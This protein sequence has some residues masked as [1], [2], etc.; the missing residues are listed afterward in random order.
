MKKGYW[1]IRTYESGIIGEKIKYWVKGER[2]SGKSRRKE[3][4]E[5]KKQEQ[6]EYSATKALARLLN[7]NY[8]EG[9]ILLGFDY[10]DEG[11]KK[12]IRYLDLKHPDHGITLEG[13]I[14]KELT[15]E[16]RDM[17]IEAAWHEIELCIRRT[18]RELKKQSQELFSVA[19]T[20]DMDGETKEHVRVHHH[21]VVK[22]G[23]EKIFQEK[24]KALGKVD[25]K[26]LSKQADYLPIAEY[27]IK[28]VRHIP[29]AKKFRSSR[30]LV[31]PQPSD[32]V[33][34][35]DAEI[36]I[37]KGGKLL[38]RQEYRNSSGS[39]HYQPQYI[40]YIIPEDKRRKRESDRK[41]NEEVQRL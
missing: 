38:F 36:R 39:A 4:S 9:D 6:N 18:S 32:R 24:W 10:S 8:Q 13:L 15:E 37:P 29:D 33:S 31:R 40:R 7:E 30:N 23:C 26:P 2:P 12:L 28:Q 11:L 21:L 5:I 16:Q 3:K 17:I 20:S 22:A 1:I 27:L 35:S 25:W 19:I 41:G 14:A 34:T